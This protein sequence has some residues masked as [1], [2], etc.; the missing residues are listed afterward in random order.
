MSD[1]ELW[2]MNLSKSDVNLGDLGVKVPMGKTVNLF[3][4]NPYLTQAKVDAS[5]DGGSLKKRLSGDSP[6]L[7]VVSGPSSKRPH[8]LD[9]LQQD[10][11]TALY[12]KKVNSSVVIES[13]PVDVEQDESFDFADYGVD[14]GEDV[15]QAREDGAVVVKA[16]EDE[17]PK[18]PES[19]ELKPQLQ[20]STVSKQSAVVMQNLAE[21][22]QHPAGKMSEDAAGPD[23]PFV[24][25]KPPADEPSE[26][27]AEQE[28]S[29]DATEVTTA[30]ASKSVVVEAKQDDT[31]TEKAPQE[32]FDA[33]AATKTKE[34]AIVMEIKETSEDKA[35]E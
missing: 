33:K 35:S 6:V 13:K 9:K 26:P 1:K 3:K 18:A 5:M 23:K 27:A 10:D 19:A 4:V 8:N 16:K 29:E 2:L 32:S 34:G 14:I 20:D 7:K 15:Q 21:S 22:A 25:V 30:E 17:A 24:V 28:A 31:P 11:G 12:A